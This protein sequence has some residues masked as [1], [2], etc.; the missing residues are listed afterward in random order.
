MGWLARLFSARRQAGVATLAAARAEPA[1]AVPALSV[2][3]L[4]LAVAPTHDAWLPWLFGCGA[5]APVALSQIELRSIQALDKTLALPR[6]PDDLLPRAAALIPQLMAA[7]R[8]SELPVPVLAQRFSKDPLLAAAVLRLARSPYY[9][10]R[11]EVADL[12]QAIALIGVYGLHAVIGRMVLK[13]LYD[14]PPG[15]LSALAAARLW[16]HAQVLSGHAC[17]QA[18]AAGLPA[19]DGYLA[20]LLS[21]T[22][23]IIALRVLDRSGAGAALPP[24]HAFATLLA[25]RA[26]RLFG[27]A[28]QRWN[29]S[30]GFSALAADAAQ[31]R[32]AS[33]ALPLAAVLR[34]AQAACLAELLA[35]SDQPG[36]SID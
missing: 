5:L 36:V 20:G 28:A 26:H 30:E 7:L 17:G 9:R 19:F 15:T 29:I 33:S 35:P 11:G 13:P 23:W 16:E 24:S 2:P 1:K 18:A 21:N 12:A 22:G 27:R 3:P 6:L 8:Q 10:A 34:N 25:E 32:L 4:P 31:H 14:A